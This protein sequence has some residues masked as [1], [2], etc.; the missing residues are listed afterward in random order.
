MKKTVLFFFGMLFLSCGEKVVEEPENL[1]PKDKMTNILC[2][3][4]LLNSTQ[5]AF[6]SA[7][8]K[9]GIDIMEFLYEKYDIDSTQF[10]QSDLYY[11]SIPLE[12]QSIYEDVDARIEKRKNAIEATTKRRN[13]SIRDA[14]SHRRDSIK[15]LRKEKDSVTP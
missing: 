2:D 13:D 5:S 8:D 1:I 11:A 12:Y 4:A 15:A 3:L 7:F 10:A 6:S 14:Q 9:T